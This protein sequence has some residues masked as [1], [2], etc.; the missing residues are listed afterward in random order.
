MVDKFKVGDMVRETEHDNM[1]GIK[2]A[3][4][5][6]IINVN[7]EWIN[8]KI[9][10]H[11]DKNRIGKV[12]KAVNPFYFELIEEPEEDITRAAII[13]YSHGD[14]FICEDKTTGETITIKSPKNEREFYTNAK[15]AIDI[16]Q[17]WKDA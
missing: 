16:L 15:R 9:L 13:I 10:D 12:V 5:V 8:I 17:M 6:R 1:E 14:D 3:E 4:V 7:G 2:R 11:K